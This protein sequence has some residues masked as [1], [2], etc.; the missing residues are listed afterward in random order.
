M[1]TTHI[2]EPGAAL[3]LCSYLVEA[4]TRDF[5][6]IQ[7][8][9]PRPRTLS[10]S[11]L[12]SVPAQV[13]GVADEVWCEMD[14][15]PLLVPSGTVLDARIERE[16]GAGVSISPSWAGLQARPEAM[17][18]TGWFVLLAADFDIAIAVGCALSLLAEDFE[19]AL[20]EGDSATARAN[21]GLLACMLEPN[22][23]EPVVDELLA[24]AMRGHPA[25]FAPG[26]RWAMRRLTSIRASAGQPPALSDDA[27]M[28]YRAIFRCPERNGRIVPDFT[29]IALA[30][31]M[32]QESAAA[33]PIS[34]NGA[35]MRLIAEGLFANYYGGAWN[36]KLAR[37]S[38]MW[39]THGPAGAK[40]DF[41]YAHGL[42]PEDFIEG[43]QQACGWGHAGPF[44]ADCSPEVEHSVLDGFIRDATTP[45]SCSKSC[46]D[47]EGM[48]ADWLPDTLDIAR[49]CLNDR[50]HPIIRLSDGSLVLSS[51]RLLADRAV[52]Q[53]RFSSSVPAQLTNSILGSMYEKYVWEVL[54]R[55][56]PSRYHIVPERLLM[57]GAGRTCDALVIDRTAR[58]WLF[59]EA[60]LLTNSRRIADGD[61]GAI[62]D[63]LDRCE[64]KLGQIVATQRRASEIARSIGVPPPVA[65]IGL[66]VAEAPLPRNPVTTERMR[67]NKS[68]LNIRPSN[69][70]RWLCS[71]DEL[72]K[73]VDMG[74]NGW[75]PASLVQAWQQR[76]ADIPLGASMHESLRSIS[77]SV[78]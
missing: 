23:P 62:D 68:R 60:G 41:N 21:G 57:T 4:P 14:E 26:V 47:T 44:L 42:D 54:N 59:V 40:A 11:T 65:T 76:P 71:I 55:L 24:R 37:W 36:R 33:D 32:V 69:Q 22:L 20:L 49:D 43:V 72:E 10:G 25:F 75:S 31:W 30:F 73:L 16:L 66:V 2:P 61:Q 52:D 64:G 1:P 15:V 77:R 70:G 18:E 46:C 67:A 58:E 27:E 19:T 56:D 7:P 9:A 13:S 12:R 74:V 39:R 5:P 78:A 29:H 34:G 6:E 17:A 50:N 45:S 35:A 38:S 28:L 3:Y 8:G 51:K 48:S 63:M 53:F